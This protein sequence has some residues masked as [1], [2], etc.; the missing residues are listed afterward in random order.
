MSS[1]RSGLFLMGGSGVGFVLRFLRNVL[2]A[3]LISVEDY[4]IASTFMVAVSF[5]DMSTNLNIGQLMIQDRRGDDPDFVAAT[6]GVEVARGILLSLFLLVCAGP[7]AALF[8]QSHLVWA[9][10]VLAIIP[11]VKGFMHPDMQ[12]LQRALRFAPILAGDVGMLGLTLILV[13]PLAL[14]LGDY[15]IMLAVY[16]I[17]TMTRVG[18]SF[19]MAERP[20][21]IGWAREVA[22]KSVQF[23]WPLTLSGLVTFAA[24]QGDRIIVA[25]RFGAEALGLF[26]AAMTM[27]MP[28]VSQASALARTFFLP[29]LAKVQDEAEGFAY[30]ARF[31]LQATLCAG[32]LTIV[33]FVLAGPPVFLLVFGDRYADGIVF[34]G[35][36]GIVFGMQLAKTGP[37]IVALSRGH[38]F[39]M[40]N[41]NLVRLAFLPLALWVAIRGGSAI[42]V[43]AVGALGQVCGFAMAVFMLTR[44]G[45]MTNLKPMALPFLAGAGVL[46]ASIWAIFSTSGNVVGLPPTLAPSPPSGWR[47]CPAERCSGSFFGSFAAGP[48]PGTERRPVGEHRRKDARQ[49][50]WE[51]GARGWPPGWPGHPPALLGA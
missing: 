38:T 18:I 41:S 32:L 39:N 10:Q 14:W 35:V 16:V 12:R 17:E 20:F 26:S 50:V 28:P 9:Y 21:R 13:W 45:D 40:L 47:S 6:K 8:S 48:R 3:R 7:I 23:A 42:E 43:V 37:N 4:G 5:I 49:W 24:L 51:P 19:L 44:S 27:I 15:R 46:A 22:V 33:G 1:L 2:V 25:N 11:A 36:L 30:R 29:L 31:T 34:V